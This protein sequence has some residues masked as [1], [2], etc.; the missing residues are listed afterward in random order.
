MK[1]YDF[2]PYS[3][4]FPLLFE[5][6]KERMRAYISQEMRIEHI[7]STSI[8]NLGGKGIIDIGI[9]VDKRNM[10][11]VLNA[12]QG[13]GYEFNPTFSTQDRFYLV[14]YLPDTQ[15]ESRRY[16]VHVT[17]PESIDWGKLL[18]FRDYLKRN[19][20]MVREYAELKMVA[21]READNNGEKYRDLKAPF[22]E[23]IISHIKRS[24]DSS[25]I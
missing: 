21:A 1:K 13:I 23:K 22:I 12:L 16:H 9:A 4:I 10:L 6:E 15:E 24:S 7:G 2:K 8:P 20:D 19:P 14:T 3:I 18:G 17:Y 5:K 11:L 25:K